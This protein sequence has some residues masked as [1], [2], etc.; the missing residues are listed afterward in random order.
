MCLGICR[1]FFTCSLGEFF[2]MER[3]FRRWM[4][5]VARVVKYRRSVPLCSLLSMLD[6]RRRGF[7]VPSR[8]ELFLAAAAALQNSSG[9][10]SP[11]PL[12][13]T[14]PPASIPTGSGVSCARPA[15]CSPDCG[16]SL[17]RSRGPQ[18]VFWRAEF[19]WPPRLARSK[20]CLHGQLVFI[21]CGVGFVVGY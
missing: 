19:Q 21:L 15:G 6:K 5:V 10:L 8:P 1:M 9:E 17:P 13:P 2:K 3:D 4:L 20:D 12:R 14:P 18:G 11:P 7:L 16:A